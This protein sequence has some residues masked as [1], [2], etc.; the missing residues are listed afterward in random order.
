MISRIS[1]APRP[2]S[3]PEKNIGF[4]GRCVITR[5][6]KSTI[7]AYKAKEL[8]LQQIM[9][10]HIT[11]IPGSSPYEPIVGYSRAVVAHGLIYVSGTTAS[12]D[13][14]PLSSDAG[15]QAA[16]ALAIIARVLANAGASFSDVVRTRMYVVDIVT[17]A[18][19]VGRAHGDVF[20]DFRP[21]ASMIGCSALIDPRMLVEIECEAVAPLTAPL[22]MHMPLQPLQAAAAELP[23]PPPEESASRASEPKTVASVLSKTSEAPC[24][25]LAIFI[26]DSGVY[27]CTF[28]DSSRSVDDISNAK[29]SESPEVDSKVDSAPI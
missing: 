2:Q 1:G 20:R 5:D 17:N 13:G 8:L 26:L 29:R 10:C 24:G 27:S 23:L 19:A 7:N 3:R 14:G 25:V 4:R 11:R 28:P 21:C 22:H 16:A 12:S 6:Q 9:S 18:A 15:E